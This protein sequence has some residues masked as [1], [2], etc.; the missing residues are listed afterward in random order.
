M[1]SVCMCSVRGMHRVVSSGLYV[2]KEELQS[3]L[4]KPLSKHHVSA[5]TLGS[6][7]ITCDKYAHPY[8]PRVPSLSHSLLFV[9]SRSERCSARIETCPAVPFI[10]ITTVS[11]T[12]SY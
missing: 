1:C 9:V 11:V 4:G 3:L 2:H 5:G 7:S 6:G 10:I 12:L 8:R